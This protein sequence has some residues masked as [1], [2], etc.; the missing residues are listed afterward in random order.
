MWLNEGQQRSH[1]LHGLKIEIPIP[2]YAN[3]HDYLILKGGL[4]LFEK[5]PLSAKTNV[6]VTSD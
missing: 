4:A 1:H 5:S 2:K 6:R 3:F